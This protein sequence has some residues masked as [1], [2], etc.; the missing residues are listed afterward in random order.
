MQYSKLVGLYR[1]LEG[2][3][4]RLEKTHYISE[5][6][7]Q[8]DDL[9][10]LALLI[11]GTVFP[12]WSDK[13][14]GV[15]SRLVIKAITIA[16]GFGVSEIEESWKETGDLGESAK[17]LTQGK[18]QSTLFSHVLT[19][20][21]VFSNLQKLADIEGEGSVDRKIKL[22][23]ELLTSAK[24]DEA[25][26]IIRTVL[27]D[28][29]VGVGDGTLRDAIVWA[30]V[31][32][33]QYDAST[34]EM[35]LDDEERKKY[36]VLVD[37]VQDAYNITND[38][39]EVAS[40]IKEKGI[41]SLQELG[42]QV[43]KPIKVM[44]FQKA[45]D[46][47]DAFSIVG[48]PCALEYKY[49]G[50]RVQVHKDKEK[51]RVFTRRLEEV[52]AQFPEVVEYVKEFVDG[53]S[54]VLD[55][56][57]VGYDVKTGKHLPFQKISQRIKRKYDIED[58]AKKFPVELHVFDIM[59]FE[60]MTLIKKSFKER[61]EW[62]ERIVK[63]VDK[64]IQPA[65]NLVT[66]NIDEANQFYSDALQSGNEGIMAKNLDGVYKPGSRVGYGV[67]IKPVMDG[68]DLVI[69]GAEW[70]EGKRSGW[71]TSFA[72][73]CLDETGNLKEIGKVGTGIKEKTEGVTFAQL[74]SLLKPLVIKEE[75][76]SVD[77]KPKIVVEINF[78]EI[79]KSPTYDSGYALRFPRLITIREDKPV[80]EASTIGQIEDMYLQ[81]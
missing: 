18:T 34:N 49:D 63:K 77:V 44:L 58:M 38:L 25:K 36:G 29:R 50:F 57:V 80:S 14:M 11:Q 70:G 10:K 32:T 71:L 21:K 79:Q 67:K 26:Y 16:T 15:A 66:D 35:T 17:I 51:I 62:I 7:K 74:T 42:L 56:E 13:K 47:P 23:S 78:E 12:N 27:E 4:K 59:F 1:Q 8:T 45:K 60:G 19:L 40:L 30:F 72:L 75:G 76:R 3:S 5:L 53:N 69:V 28:L 33:P 43:G 20:E 39:G 52:T 61:R 9:N 22:I 48:V 31:Y 65:L 55:A 37:Q 6:F 64:K 46:I 68:L 24:P 2:T 73:A 41:A 54:F 81:Q